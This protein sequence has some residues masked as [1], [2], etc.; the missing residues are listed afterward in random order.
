MPNA[1]A[2]QQHPILCHR[3]PQGGY[4]DRSWATTNSCISW[5]GVEM[6]SSCYQH[7]Q[8]AP[9]SKT[10]V[11]FPFPA[12]HY[13]PQDRWWACAHCKH[14]GP[15]NS[16]CKCTNCVLMRRKGGWG[17]ACTVEKVS[18]ASWLRCEVPGAVGLRHL[19]HSLSD[20]CQLSAASMPWLAELKGGKTRILVAAW[21]LSK[22]GFLLFHKASLCRTLWFFSNR[23]HQTPLIKEVFPIFQ[24]QLDNLIVSIFIV[25]LLLGP[26]L[27]KTSLF[28]EHP[29]WKACALVL[30]L[31]NADI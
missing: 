26:W 12:S 31:C 30:A 7:L 6:T 25:E 10:S 16:S 15:V 14:R 24:K 19:W 3:Y 17:Y 18:E 1:T 23:Q 13:F 29:S 5:C 2:Q 21:S 20:H 22:K 8:T 4:G 11:V 27:E 9:P 28:K